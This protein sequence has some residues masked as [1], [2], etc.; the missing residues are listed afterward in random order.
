MNKILHDL[1]QK[2]METDN[3]IAQMMGVVR[4]RSPKR[5]LGS[6]FTRIPNV[7][8]VNVKMGKMNSILK[9]MGFQKRV[10][11][12]IETEKLDAEDR[13]NKYITKQ[14]LRLRKLKKTNPEKF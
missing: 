8:Y 1:S 3:S 6:S 10:N 9:A 5:I 13:M 12:K 2:L 7:R 14:V 11:T 4:Y